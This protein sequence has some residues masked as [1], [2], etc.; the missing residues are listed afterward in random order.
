[1]TWEAAKK[2]AMKILGSGASAP[3][4]PSTITAIAA[5]RD[6][7]V[8]SAQVGRRSEP[9]L[10]YASVLRA[11]VRSLARRGSTSRIAAKPTSKSATLSGSGMGAIA[12]ALAT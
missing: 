9:P 4:K 3:D 1:M 5:E 2:Q 7:S 11:Q 6:R 10:R 8:D 12:T